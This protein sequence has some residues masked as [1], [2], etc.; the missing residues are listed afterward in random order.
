MSIK[1]ACLCG[2]PIEV[3]D[4]LAGTSYKCRA[5]GANVKVPSF[6][7]AS[8]TASALS[9]KKCYLCKQNM[10]A[11]EIVC[12]HCGWDS[13]KMERT[14]HACGGKIALLPGSGLNAPLLN[15]AVIFASLICGFLFGFIG[16]MAFGLAI[17]AFVNLYTALTL[18]YQCKGCGMDIPVPS[19]LENKI[20]QD[21]RRFKRAAHF[22]GVGAAAVGSLVFGII[23][24][25]SVLS[26]SG[27]DLKGALP[28]IKALEAKGLS[29][30]PELIQA[31][32]D[33]RVRVEASQAI[34]KMGCTLTLGQLSV[35][36]ED[37]DRK[38]RYDVANI[39]GFYKEEAAAAVPELLQALKEEK[40]YT[41]PFS[42]ALQKIGLPAVKPLAG[43]LK[44]EDRKFRAK[45]AYVLMH[46][47][48]KS[49]D[50]LPALTE[51]L[52]DND[53]DTLAY[54][55]DTL[56]RLGSGASAAIPELSLVLKHK[57]ALIRS[58][59]AKAIGRI[60][61]NA[62]SAVPH[63]ITGLK[64]A[65]AGVR[66]ACAEALGSLGPD[67]SESIPALT[68]ASNDLDESVRREAK[69][70]LKAIQKQ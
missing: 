62:Y 40:E 50:A 54:V 18:G 26:F 56:G 13:N 4:E 3:L 9:E 11:D 43:A 25:V 28:D 48:K 45:A 42:E 29:A 19:V 7:Q 61:Q 68:E 63:L 66:H 46:L 60:R 20:E 12:P 65:D 51:A 67:A 15:S 41:Y 6:K 8:S 37:S 70:A 44:D 69:Q 47:G 14:C 23:W 30:L 59:A 52:K 1:F 58:L 49:V 55:L 35:A 31:L 53:E 17:L 34:Q 64:D 2:K 16:A 38:L 5:C 32:K 39:I 27:M 22:I 33:D 36:L 24:I 10:P 57:T 21:S